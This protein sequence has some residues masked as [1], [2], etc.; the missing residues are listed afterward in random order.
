MKSI[1]DALIVIALSVLY[2]VGLV[3]LFAYSARI[4]FP[5]QPY[6][7]KPAWEVYTL[8]G[9]QGLMSILIVASVVAAGVALRFSRHVFWYGLMV[10]VPITLD[11]AWDLSKV[12]A[13]QPMS[14]G[15][16][17]LHIEQFLVR[18]FVPAILASA[19]A[20]FLSSHGLKPAARSAA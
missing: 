2:L 17:W 4:D 10:A 6:L 20:R 7:G 19:F 13:I 8:L 3:E 15:H 9:L 11:S 1:V 14:A 18:L 5:W 16:W 12:L